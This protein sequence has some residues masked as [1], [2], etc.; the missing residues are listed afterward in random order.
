MHSPE[1]T[2][3]F[4]FRATGDERG[5]GNLQLWYTKD[6]QGTASVYTAGKFDGLALVVDTYGG[7]VSYH[8]FLHF[9]N[10]SRSL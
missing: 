5:G 6:K 7:R 4:Q 9:E 1:W 8:D 10:R 3:E 2:V